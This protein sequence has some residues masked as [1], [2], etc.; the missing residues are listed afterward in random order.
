MGC[1]VLSG[2]V[3]HAKEMTEHRYV[4]D[5]VVGDA[6]LTQE[7]YMSMWRLPKIKGQKP[8]G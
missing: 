4:E 6:N 7:R 5:V 1:A 3:L 2:F 8:I